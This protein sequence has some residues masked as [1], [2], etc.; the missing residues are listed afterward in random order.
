[1]PLVDGHND[2]P[3]VIREEAR[4][5]LAR[6]DLRERR[7]TGDTDIPRLRE[8]SVGGSVLERLDPVRSIAAARARSSSRSTSR[9]G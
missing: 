2:L 3:W 7:P 5:D 4:G 8:G 9:A 6:Y 1:M